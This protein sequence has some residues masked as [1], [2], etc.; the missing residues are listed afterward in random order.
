MALMIQFSFAQEKTVTGTVTSQSDGLPLPGVSVV[1]KGTTRGQQT[2]FDGNYSLTASVGE[3]VVFSSVGYKTVER[4]VG[5][6]NTIDVAFEDDVA[7]LDEVVVVAYGAVKKTSVTAAQ[8]TVKSET[9]ENVP[10]PS[11]DQVLQGQ[12]AGLSIAANNGAPGSAATIILRGRSSFNA[13]SNLEPLFIVDGVPVDEDAFSSLNN[14]DIANLTVLKDAAASALYGNRG[15]NGVVIVTTKRGAFNQGLSV[16]YRTQF[17]VSNQVDPQID[18]L[19]SRQFLEYQRFLGSGSCGACTDGEI[20]FF[21]QVNTDWT[22]FLLQT[23]QTQS[24]EITLTAGGEKIRN[25]TSIGYFEQDGTTLR[26]DFQRLSLRTNTDLRGERLNLSSNISLNFTRTNSSPQTANGGG[27]LQNPF[28]AAYISLPFL[29]P[30]NSDGSIN[31]FGLPTGPDGNVRDPI[32]GGVINPVGFEQTPFV[33]QNAAAFD[34]D[35]DEGIRAV[36]GLNATYKLH[37]KVTVGSNFGLDYGQTSIL[38]GVSPLGLQGQFN[39]PNGTATLARGSITRGT[40]RDLRLNWANNV[41]YRDT[42]GDKH[43]VEFGVYSEFVMRQFRGI[44]FNAAGLD[45]RL[46]DS[47]DGLVAGITEEPDGTQPF[48]PNV[49]ILGVN[50]L[51]TGLFSVFALGRYNYDDKYSIEANIRRDASSRFTGDNEWGTFFSVSGRWNLTSE[52]WL[53]D[54]SWLDNL[55]LRAGFGEVGNQEIGFTQAGVFAT[56]DLF[57]TPVGIGGS[58]GLSRA[59]LWNPNLRWEPKQSINIGVDFAFFNNRLSGALDIYQEDT[60]DILTGAPISASATGFETQNNNLGSLRNEGI[61]LAISYDIIQNNDVNWNVFAN[62]SF[63]RGEVLIIDGE[64]DFL[65][66]GDF[67]SL[68]VGEQFGTLFAARFA[69]VNPANGMPLF[70]DADGNLTQDITQ[71]TGNNRVFDEDRTRDPNFLGGFGTNFSYKGFSLTSLFSYA[72]GQYRDNGT[73]G[74]LEDP[75]LVGISNQSERVLR[76]WQQPGDITD[77]PN[78]A[79]FNRFGPSGDRFIENSSFLRLRNVTVAYTFNSEQLKDKLKS[80]R[81]YL[82]AQNLF[83]ISRWRGFDPESSGTA[84]ANNSFFDFPVPRTFTVGLDVNF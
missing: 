76:A 72:V 31:L 25:F 53:S 56:D 3:T 60:I 65:E 49:D 73:L 48:I 39:V 59:T 16:T 57:A 40:L 11:L 42:Y 34:T 15:S 13:N 45:P 63:N 29:S 37:D 14:N 21:S 5:S 61:E 23:G 36:I 69:G 4:V 79:F 62:G 26:S 41:T 22:E 27:S 44:A 46:Q 47:V 8:T 12:V 50:T 1:V 84:T 67:G 24:H 83:T 28:L 64:V 54:V 68:Q 2:D 9:I 71:N 10:I 74:V 19:N 52:K 7:A 33:A 66:G 17:G 78:N 38:D 35:R 80:L 30:F 77:I 51:D 43:N 58:Q 75:T 82:Q 32:N 55:A 70:L 18:F 6:S 81:F 20:D